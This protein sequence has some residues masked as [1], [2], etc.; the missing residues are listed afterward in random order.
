MPLTSTF[1]VEIDGNPLP[2]DV[3]PLLTTAHV[4]D[5]QRLPDLFVLRF[6][7]GDRV[8]V[9]KTGV[10]V[11]AKVKVS[12][13]VPDR[14]TPQ[15]LITGEVTALEAE[16]D[17]GGTF[18]V[19]RGYDPAHRLFRGRRS[20]AY[21]QMTAS[22]IATKVAQRA[23]LRVGT[24]EA[25][26]TVFDHVSQFGVT[27]WE[28]LSGL[29][30]EVGYEISVRDGAFAFTGPQEAGNA[31][32]PAGRPGAEPL[33][34]RLGT[35]LLRFRSVVTAAQQVAEVEV[36]G[37]DVPGKQALTSTVPAT[38]KGA[39][40]RDATP[41]A[42]ADAF[43]SARYVST[44]VPYATQAEVDSVAR[45][46]AEE[47]AG[48]F[49]E[50]EGVVRGNPALRAGEAV[51]IDG[52]GSPFDG[53][54]TVTTSR[55]RFEPGSGYTTAFS[56]TGRAE[57][58]LLSLAS[59][60]S[61][62]QR[63]PG[64]VPGVVTDVN[65]PQMLGR[66][67][68]ALPWLSDTYTSTWARTVQ[69]GAGKDR[70]W[71]VLPEVGDEVLV[72]FEQGDARTPY[73]L[74]GLHNGVDTP[75]VHAPDLVD[76]GTGAVNRRSMVSRLGHRID[77]L[78]ETGGDDGVLVESGD[79]ALSLRLDGTKTAVTV[80]SDGTVVIEGTKGITVD[81]ASA[82]LALKA[83]RISLTATSGVTVDG[84]GGNVSVTSGAAL[85]LSGTTA[86]LSG[87]TTTD[88]TA[89]AMCKVAAAMVK[90]N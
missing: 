30:R 48:A 11:G 69:L 58:S 45:S 18:T 77:L 57:R 19:I 67:K 70:G 6:R 62:S 83:G 17:G 55:H 90:I 86:K 59:G 53:K 20:E 73:V 3:V 71:M 82:D 72:A 42:M 75:K 56:V 60:G 66:V 52:L 26:S 49:A 8:V 16:F 37:W 87:S 9:S 5:S 78:D 22:D 43:G 85:E 35:D 61:S 89:G 46:L 23:G 79:A 36:R 47:V 29:A 13:L 4:D 12:V 80:H 7:D 2:A 88:V 51:S 1:V 68:V 74:G 63:T 65:D 50:F 25:T 27:D 38:T 39:V 10:K 44:D 15:P 64:V 21:T 41:K 40:L 28:F 54:Y 31:P 32:E 84:G 24:V 14:T 33:V 76:G 81:A 34:L